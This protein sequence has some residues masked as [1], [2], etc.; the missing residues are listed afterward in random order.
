MIGKLEAR[1]RE[2]TQLLEQVSSACVLCHVQPSCVDMGH[3]L[4]TGGPWPGTWEWHMPFL[5][6]QTQERWKAMVEK[7]QAESLQRSL[8][9]QQK[10][11]MQQLSM[12]QEEREKEKVRLNKYLQVLFPC[13]VSLCSAALWHG[14]EDRAGVWAAASFTCPW[15]PSSHTWLH[16]E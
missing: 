1:L 5:C 11:M 13:A 16:G 10:F 9:E 15:P 7:A 2:Q 8:E 12:V 6:V 14:V 3:D 4:P